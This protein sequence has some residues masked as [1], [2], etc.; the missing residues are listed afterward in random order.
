MNKNN[1]PIIAAIIIV[2]LLIIIGAVFASGILAHDDDEQAAYE[3]NFIDGEQ[4]IKTITVKENHL[5]TRINDPVKEGYIFAGWYTDQELTN[6]FTF[7]D[8]YI[9]NNLTLYA[10][11]VKTSEPEPGDITYTVTFN[12]NGANSISPQI[13]K[14]GDKAVKPAD[15]I[16]PLLPYSISNHQLHLTLLFTL[17]SHLLVAE[18]AA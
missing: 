15:L 5:V 3:V 6:E 1:K 17:N 14:A 4:V 12:T 2:A 10:K 11:W 7:D 16:H 8:T 9:T 13:V 18:A